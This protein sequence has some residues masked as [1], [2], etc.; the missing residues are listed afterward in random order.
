MYRKAMLICT[1]VGGSVQ[2]LV[3]FLRVAAGIRLSHCQF[4][5]AAY[6]VLMPKR[7]SE[8]LILAIIFLAIGFALMVF[9]GSILKTLG[10]PS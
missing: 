2:K 1:V 8:L 10:W 3:S 7:R 6:P 4:C 5:L 9:I